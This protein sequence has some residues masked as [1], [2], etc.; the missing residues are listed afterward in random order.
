MIYVEVL[1]SNETIMTESNETNFKLCV[2]N[3]L[4]QHVMN[5]ALGQNDISMFSFE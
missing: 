1:I 2:K 3:A 4:V 5:E